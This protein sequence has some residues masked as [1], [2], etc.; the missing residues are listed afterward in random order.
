VRLR[1]RGPT[2]FLEVMDLEAL[3]EPAVEAAGLELVEATFAKEGGRRVLRVVVD[4]EGGADLDTIAGASERIS[5]RLD[6]EDFGG[7]PY[8][9]E[10]TSPGVERPLKKPE[11]FAA[12]VGEKVRIKTFG[13][14]E[15][16][17]T[18][19]G[20]IAAADDRGVI[21]ETEEG[22]RSLAHA[23]ISSARTV[24]EWGAGR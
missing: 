13:P 10:V 4:R 3:I 8:T 11:D 20:I 15:G 9:L 16:T 18:H 22:R 21:L 5:R 19:T 23:D 12:R 1:G 17:R 2:F 24:F 14:V 6:V 7:G